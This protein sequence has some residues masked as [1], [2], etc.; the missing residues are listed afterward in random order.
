MVLS[1]QTP[2]HG[3][4]GIGPRWGPSS[5]LRLLRTYA[6]SRRRSRAFCVRNSSLRGGGFL[7]DVAGPGRV[8]LDPGAHGCCECDRAD[9]AAL[10]GGRLGTN[11]LVDHGC[12]VLQQATI[13]EVTLADHQ[14]DDRVAIRS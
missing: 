4:R 14:V 1:K 7:D 2:A 12:I 3:G 5:R 13:V 10:G 9:V 8:D 6:L 11:Q